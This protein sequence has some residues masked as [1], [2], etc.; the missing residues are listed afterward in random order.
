MKLS[1][2]D[3]RFALWETFRADANDIE[4]EGYVR[5]ENKEILIAQLKKTAPGA[6]NFQLTDD[7]KALIKAIR[8]ANLSKDDLRFALWS[9]SSYTADNFG[10]AALALLND[11][12][13][14]IEG[15]ERADQDHLRG[16]TKKVEDHI[17]DADKKEES[18][19]G[20]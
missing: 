12:E 15:Y 8:K 4:I 5:E 1:K 19:A 13:L 18:E 16:A 14:E 11:G 17:A 7:E 6:E 20:K 10:C 9:A 3:L 2:N